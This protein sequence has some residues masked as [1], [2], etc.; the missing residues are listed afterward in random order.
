VAPTLGAQTWAADAESLRKRAAELESLGFASISVGDHLSPRRTSA[1]TA[2]AVIAEA[3]TRVQVGPLVLNNDF[4]HPAV[5]AREAAALADLSA[6]RFEL[7]LGAGYVRAE[8]ERAGIPFLP[9]AVRA[10]R[11]AESAQI[12]R[13]LLAGETVDFAGEHYTI[14]GESL[15]PPAHAVPILIGGNSREVHAAAAE[16][17]DI[18]GLA[19]FSPGRTGEEAEA[20][21]TLAGLER[22]VERLRDL[23]GGRFGQL[24]LHTLVQWHDVTD[25]RRAAA[26]RAAAALELPLESVLD[27]PYVLLG[28]ADEIA[29]RLREHHERFGIARWVIFSDRPDLAP[30]E[31]LVP[32]LERL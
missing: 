1:L 9:A 3:T 13:A 32:V 30:A 24:E 14:R 8:Y 15:E 25:D 10:A 29:D 4:R 18:L 16:H 26:E 12:L 2:C 19:G 27:S 31:S 20:D 28:T 5:L 17:A 7:G 6:G 21:F 23:A 22:Q 11:L